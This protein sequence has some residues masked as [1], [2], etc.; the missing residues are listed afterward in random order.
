MNLLENIKTA[1]AIIGH[2]KARSFLTMLGIIIGV[3]SVVIIISVGAGAQSLILNQ[4]KSMGSNL[5]GVLPGKSDDNGPPA[6]AMGI[7]ITSLKY[8]D[9]QTLV[10][11]SDHITAGSVYVKGA[12]TVAWEF[13][14]IDTTFVGTNA[15][16]V[17]VEEADVASGHFFTQADEKS[18]ATVAVIGS[19]VADEL[20]NGGITPI[21][22]KIKI[23]KTNFTIIGVMAK[24]GVSGFENQDNQ[25]FIPV[26][27]AQKMLL[28]INY[29]SFAR[30]KIDDAV[31]V[32]SSMEYAR[33]R[34][35]ELHNIDDPN[36]DDFSVRSMAQGLEV[37]T[38]VTNALRLFLASVA[39]I[40]LI[41]GGIG[42][43]NIMLAAVTERTREIGLRK[44][45]GAKNINIMSQ[46]LIETSTITFLGGAIGIVMGV[47]ISILV[48]LIAR[49]LGYDWDLSIS[50]FGII[51]A[52][53]VSVGVGLLFG[54]VPARRASVLDP[55]EA[56]RY[57]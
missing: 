57:E 47:L 52:T 10:K 8:D 45:L 18:N 7:L 5:V 27:T 34:L 39:S 6:S 35:R 16:Y 33:L 1:W 15:D 13:N 25:I 56:L 9:I 44:A 4:I 17:I 24:R 54:L 23:K 20:F 42:I 49:Q 50:I 32:E 29:V 55:I 37:F 43:M 31:N 22:Q 46:F 51:L 21:G 26:T 53:V 12:E 30:I 2:N 11:E 48:A 40:A 3:M 28:G 14:K 36:N 38:T 19:E 41:V